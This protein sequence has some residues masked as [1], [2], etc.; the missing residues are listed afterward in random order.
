MAEVILKTDVDGLGIVG[1]VVKVADGFARNYLMPRNLAAPANAVAVKRLAKARAAR[2]FE[3]GEELEKA[4][5]A[6]EKLKKVTLEIAAKTG[7][8][9]KLYGSV[10]L[11]EIMEAAEKANLVLDKSQYLLDGP[12]K[13]LGEVSVAIRIHAQVKSSIQVRV[14]EE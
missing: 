10:G 11:T 7:E 14:I 8:E 9:G 2:E 6:S 12:I 3:L 13:E 4:E 5:K 1:D